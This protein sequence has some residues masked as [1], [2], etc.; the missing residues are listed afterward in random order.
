M[1]EEPRAQGAD[2]VAVDQFI[3]DRIDTVPHLEALLLLWNSRPRQWSVDEMAQG[4]FVD[5]NAA[6][7]IL[8][9]LARQRLIQG[10]GDEYSYQPDTASHDRLI[11]AVDA[12][13]RRELIRITRMIHGKAPAS[14]RAFA[15]AFRIKEKE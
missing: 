5:S 3:R 14:V 6:R 1:E 9:D 11:E 12:T 2:P 8:Q 10:Y 13:Y 4:L 15:D 7:R